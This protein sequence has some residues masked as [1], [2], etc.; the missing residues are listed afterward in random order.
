VDIGVLD[1]R[2]LSILR[3]AKA[4]RGTETLTT[5]VLVRVKEDMRVKCGKHTLDV[6]A[7]A[8]LEDGLVAVGVEV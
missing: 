5:R 8:G 7:L 4:P 1:I 3:L 2:N 6:A